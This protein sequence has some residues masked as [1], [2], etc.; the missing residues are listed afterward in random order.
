MVVLENIQYNQ[1]S[2]QSDQN[3]KTRWSLGREPIFGNLFLQVWKNTGNAENFR[4][5]IN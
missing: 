5:A 2:G 4:D 1:K 3:C